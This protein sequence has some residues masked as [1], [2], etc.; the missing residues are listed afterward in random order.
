MKEQIMLIIYYRLKITISNLYA[1][2]TQCLYLLIFIILITH[3]NQIMNS[4]KI[5]LKNSTL[6]FNVNIIYLSKSINKYKQIKKIELE[7][8]NPI[9]IKKF[10]L[11]NKF[12]FKI[13]DINS[14]DIVRSIERLKSY[15][16]LT[17]TKLS[18]IKAYNIKYI[19]LNFKI[20]PILKRI[21]ISKQRTLLIPKNILINTFQK[22]IGLPKNYISI[23]KSI[24]IIKL[25]YKSRGFNWIDV[26]LVKTK[27]LEEFYLKIFE[28]KIIRI[29]L[30]CKQKNIL[31]QNFEH[32][33]EREIKQEL[34]LI[35]GYILNIKQLELG[36]IRLK[37][38]KLIN[39]CKYTITQNF[40]GL[41][42]SFKYDLFKYNQAF[43]Y[44][45]QTIVDY[46]KQILKICKYYL[47]NTTIISRYSQ[48]NYY[49][50]KIMPLNY[51]AKLI[52][53][54]ANKKINLG[55][56]PLSKYF[57]FKYYSC[58]KNPSQQSLM[59]D[60]QIIGKNTATN[61]SFSYP[62]M[63]INNFLLGYLT[64]NAYY[65]KCYTYNMLYALKAMPILTLN[66]T[67]KNAIKTKLNSFGIDILFR[68]HLHEYISLT[69]K[70][71]NEY[72][73]SNQ[74]LL[75]I[76]NYNQY[77][78]FQNKRQNT[79]F[80]SKIIS[81]VIT[82]NLIILKMQIKY[83]TLY[84]TQKLKSG[85]LFV[86][87][88]IYF[89]PFLIKQPYFIYWKKYSSQSLHAKCH[90]VFVMPKIIKSAYNNLLIFLIDI[91][92]FIGYQNC[93]PIFQTNH[94]DEKNI[95]FQNYN[96]NNN[97]FKPSFLYKIEYNLHLYNYLS[98]YIFCNFTHNLHN[99]IMLLNL[100]KYY[101][102]NNS[103][104]Y[105]INIGSGIQLNI[106][107]KKIPTLRIEY[108]ISN[109]ANSLIQLR[110]YSTYN[111]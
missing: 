45:Q 62:N 17:K 102:F 108:S 21:K 34:G 82:Q 44:K 7:G 56:K 97:I 42:I 50:S 43:F 28:G 52:I 11:R 19:T 24:N 46:Y 77:N 106:P 86:V 36:I 15:G 64:L 55:I 32:E 27:K 75:N 39:T 98:L 68:N 40:R 83:N 61:I 91:N 110:A 88:I 78:F 22:Q 4:E 59:V 49:K 81:R 30:I 73:I 111:D 58:Q 51:I 60:M 87:E 105:E 10:L 74:I 71:I 92:W 65:Y 54:E 18:F 66:N 8:F 72:N 99:K 41:N 3:I 107:I 48:Y 90:K 26:K 23:N 13:N 67:N 31:S 85:T 70:I 16:F 47:Y 63:K 38:N 6:A 95:Y 93:E 14:T 89:T 9:F 1:V 2:T 29:N 37:Q 96:K 76:H 84:L 101:I 12:S 53:L 20:N 25:W 33:I 79:K 5:I 109:K 35:H 100:T 94:K 104:Y 80:I 103:L 69:E 57:G